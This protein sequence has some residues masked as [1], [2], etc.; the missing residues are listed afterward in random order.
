MEKNYFVARVN[1]NVAYRQGN[2][3]VI[4]SERHRHFPQNLEHYGIH[5]VTLDL[6]TSYKTVSTRSLNLSAVMS[7]RIHSVLSQVLSFVY[8]PLVS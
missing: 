6:V 4:Y 8:A 5:G 2:A 3:Q 7:P 1:E